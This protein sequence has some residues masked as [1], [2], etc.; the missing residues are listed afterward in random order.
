MPRSFQ[1]GPSATV[2][3]PFSRQHGLGFAFEVDVGAAADVDG[4]PL[5]GAAGEGVRV[6]AG[7]AE[8]SARRGMT[9]SGMHMEYRE[10]GAPGRKVTPAMR[11]CTASMGELDH[12]ESPVSEH[13]Y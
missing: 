11:I 13:D 6:I 12:L 9:F 8:R 7:V 1:P 3:A 4:H 10:S 5:A 2:A